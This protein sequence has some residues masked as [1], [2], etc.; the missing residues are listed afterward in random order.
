[1]KVSY[2]AHLRKRRIMIRLINGQPRIGP[3]DKVPQSILKKARHNRA[4]IIAELN[5]EANLRWPYFN[6]CGDLV[7]PHDCPPRFRYWQDG[8]SLMDTLV[9]LGAGEEILNRYDTYRIS[10]GVNQQ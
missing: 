4:K 1:M 6:N 3:A 7:I 8:Q 2:L 10:K 9:E 5:E